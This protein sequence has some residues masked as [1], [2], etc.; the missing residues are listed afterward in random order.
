MI[1]APLIRA[2]NL[3]IGYER[4]APIL[5]GVSFEIGAGD[6]VGITGPNGGGKTTLVRALLGLLPLR[7][8]TITFGG[9]GRRPSMGYVPQQHLLDR[10]FPISV[11]EVVES[12]LMGMGGLT[13][14]AR[15]A[16]VAEALTLAG[17]EEMARRPIG[18]LSG[19]QLQRTLFA[20]AVVAKPK[21][22]VLD[23]PDSYVDAAFDEKLHSLLPELL[24]DG[25]IL[26]VSHDEEILGELTNRRFYVNRDLSEREP[27]T[28]P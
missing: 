20:R 16:A 25:A 10:Q 6:F 21:I 8:G 28:R 22:L 15:K 18:D 1:A 13:A 2:E 12:G 17:L 24:G 27:E 7:G 14:A 26:L 9:N 23:E 4:Q 5:S 19:G 3:T 11:R